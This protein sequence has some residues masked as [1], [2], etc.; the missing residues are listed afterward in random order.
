MSSGE[1]GGGGQGRAGGRWGEAL[2]PPPP[3]TK[4][5]L[6]SGCDVASSPQDPI[7]PALTGPSH[8]TFEPKAENDNN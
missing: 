6:S 3:L 8:T 7:V 4:C 5:P 2:H 1:E